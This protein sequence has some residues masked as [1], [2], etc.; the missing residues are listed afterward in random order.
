MR[1]T[2]KRHAER[3]AIL[4]ERPAGERHPVIGVISRRLDIEQAD[5]VSVRDQ[6][7]DHLQRGRCVTHLWLEAVG[8]EHRAEVL[9]AVREIQQDEGLLGKLA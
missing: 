3:R 1:G 2:S 7:A 8:E 5:A 9:A 4:G 6:A